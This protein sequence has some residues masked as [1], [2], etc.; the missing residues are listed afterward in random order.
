[1]PRLPPLRSPPP[2]ATRLGVRRAGTMEAAAYKRLY[3]EQYYDKFIAEGARPDGRPLGRARPVSLARGVVTTAQG[4]A[5]AKVGRTT[6]IAAVK[7]EPVAPTLDAPD[8]GVLEVTVE[9]PPMCSASTRPG[10]PSEEAA[11]A[12]RR[13]ADAL[14]DARVVDL[15]KLCIKEGLWAWKVSLDVYCLD[16]DGGVI[17]VG[18][19]AAV[20]ALRDCVVPFASVDDRGKVHTG[21]EGKRK[22]HNRDGPDDANPD[23]DENPSSS[24]ARCEVTVARVPVALTVGLYK[25]QRI[26]DPSAEE[27]TLMEATVTVVV[28]DAGAV[29]AV[30][31]P[32][33]TAE[34]TETTLAHCVAAAR[35]RH[36]PCAKAMDDAFEGGR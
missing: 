1:M 11:H 17:D 10:R 36:S 13:I 35:L 19:L 28:D 9:L 32:G 29:V 4:S 24:S 22:R 27:T 2:R 30:V 5:L 21:G 15:T 16:N 18:L 8:L 3:P 34:A 26:V 12:T 6:A 7:L 23:E 20:A 31:K 14:A 33:G 25:G